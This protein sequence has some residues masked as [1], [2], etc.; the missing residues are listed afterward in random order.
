MSHRVLTTVLFIF[1]VPT[2]VLTIAAEDAWYAAMRGFAFEL[3]EQAHMDICTKKGKS[4][5][6]GCH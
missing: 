2:V 1:P 3:A 6:A 4:M 5:N